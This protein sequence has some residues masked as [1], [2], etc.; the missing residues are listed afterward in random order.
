MLIMLM[1][2]SEELVDLSGQP[3]EE[4]D[5][6]PASTTLVYRPMSGRSQPTR[7]DP[8]TV[9]LAVQ[10]VGPCRLVAY[11][12]PPSLENYTYGIHFLP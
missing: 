2:E 1:Y 5:D 9:P 3:N 4:I 12:L 8:G 7:H 10:K 11:Y 6:P